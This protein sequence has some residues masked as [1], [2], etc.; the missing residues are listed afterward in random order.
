[1][2]RTLEGHE[3]GMSVLQIATGGSY[4]SSVALLLAGLSLSEWLALFGA[5]LGLLTYLTNLWFR[6]DERKRQIA[7]DKMRLQE[8][9]CNDEPR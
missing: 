6:W 9:E 8:E 1:M 4:A 2:N 7:L 5:F 3:N